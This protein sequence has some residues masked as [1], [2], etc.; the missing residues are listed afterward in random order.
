MLVVDYFA[1]R[2]CGVVTGDLTANFRDQETRGSYLE[3]TR[4]EGVRIVVEERL[5][6]VLEQNG[7]T[8]R[9]ISSVPAIDAW[10]VPRRETRVTFACVDCG[11]T[12]EVQL[13]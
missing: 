3:G 4:I 2:R 10:R 11:E 5:L 7:P 9:L 1:G 6:N 13:E 8:L 12:L